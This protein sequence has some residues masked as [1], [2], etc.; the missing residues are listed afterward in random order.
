MQQSV[1]GKLQE[2]LFDQLSDLCED[3]TN[4]DTELVWM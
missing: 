2:G 1:K 4:P 3:C